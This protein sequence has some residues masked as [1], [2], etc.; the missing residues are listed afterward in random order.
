MQIGSQNITREQMPSYDD[1][2]QNPSHLYQLKQERLQRLLQVQMNPQ[3]INQ[4]QP[5]V[6]AQ[7][8]SERWSN[9]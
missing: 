2:N 6:Q 1:F 7:T 8:Q 5:N 9:S 3:A 4:Q